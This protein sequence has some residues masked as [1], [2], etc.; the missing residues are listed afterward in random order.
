MELGQKHDLPKIQKTI[1][2]NFFLK[3]FIWF[4]NPSVLVVFEKKRKFRFFFF[5]Q[6][7]VLERQVRL[8]LLKS[9]ANQRSKPDE[10][11]TG[12]KI[13]YLKYLFRI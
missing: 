4:K 12:K 3:L 10:I 5:W 13:P 9:V 6:I 7:V 8:N 1:W 2:C 11:R